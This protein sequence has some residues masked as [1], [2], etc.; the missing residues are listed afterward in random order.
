MLHKHELLVHFNKLVVFSLDTESEFLGHFVAAF[1]VA[2]SLALAC[3][4]LRT[5]SHSDWCYLRRW[6]WH[7]AYGSRYPW[8]Y[9]SMLPILIYLI[10]GV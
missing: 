3:A 1:S 7:F 8:F 5:H 9:I 4:V 2:S 6:E 10:S